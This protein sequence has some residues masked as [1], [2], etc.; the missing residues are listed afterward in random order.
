MASTELSKVVPDKDRLFFIT[1]DHRDQDGET[2]YQ[3]AFHDGST[4]WITLANL[5]DRDPEGVQDLLYAY[6]ALDKMDDTQLESAKNAAVNDL[7]LAN[8]PQDQVRILHSLPRVEVLIALRNSR[9][10][11]RTLVSRGKSVL[12]RACG[13]AQNG[14]LKAI[15]TFA[16]IIS[17][18]NY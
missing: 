16:H 5:H 12:Q 13:S 10:L 11:I 6:N 17:V 14:T 2:W 7:R 8:A 9:V 3:A 18:A 1:G 15:N 4:E